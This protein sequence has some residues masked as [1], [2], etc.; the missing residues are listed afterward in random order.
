MFEEKNADNRTKLIC[1]EVIEI[2]IESLNGVSICPCGVTVTV[3]G[4]SLV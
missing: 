2:C 3:F 1:A 4:T